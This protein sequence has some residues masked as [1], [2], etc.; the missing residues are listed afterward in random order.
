MSGYSKNSE[1]DLVDEMYKNRPM[2]KSI[3]QIINRINSVVQEI[4][5]T[6]GDGKS[7]RYLGTALKKE[8]LAYRKPKKV[9]GG[10][11]FMGGSNVMDVMRAPIPTETTINHYTPPIAQGQSMYDKIYPEGRFVG[12]EEA[13]RKGPR[14]QKSKLVIDPNIQAQYYL[15]SD[16]DEYKDGSSLLGAA[17]VTPEQF[18]G[19]TGSGCCGSG[20]KSKEPKAPKKAK[21]PPTDWN[22]FVKAVAKHEDLP[23]MQAVKIASEYKRDGYTIEDF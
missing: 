17:L 8:K 22:L 15:D 14:K 18:F 11:Q 9:K 23:Y 7:S 21:R 16:E 4:N 20:K 13:A 5:E 6:N 2:K 3:D 19:M 1:N 12:I 10:S